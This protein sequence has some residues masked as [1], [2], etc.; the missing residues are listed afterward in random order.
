MYIGRFRYPPNSAL[1]HGN[2]SHT[3]DDDGIKTES[4]LD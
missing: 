2:L 1:V 3:L 4:G